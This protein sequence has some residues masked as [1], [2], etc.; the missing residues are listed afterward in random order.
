[1]LRTP[2]AVSKF[3]PLSVPPQE[4]IDLDNG[5]TLH[6]INNGDQPIIRFSLL[7]NSGE[8]DSHPISAAGFVPQI[9]RE[10][11]SRM[12]GAEIAEFV[13]FEGAWL[14]TR[15][16]KHFTG[17][18]VLSLTSSAPKMLD[19]MASM[20]IEPT[21]PEHAFESL[22]TK[23]VKAIEHKMARVD[24]RSQSA[25][26]EHMAGKGHPYIKTLTP[27]QLAATTLDDVKAAFRQGFSNARIH[28]FA[29]G[30]I[31]PEIRQATL[32]FARSLRSPQATYTTS[33]IV[34]MQPG[35]P[36]RHNIVMPDSIQ[37]SVSMAAPTIP[38]SHKDYIPLRIAVMALGGY[39]GSRLMTSIREEKGLT[40]GISAALEGSHEA[41]N[42]TINAQCDP[43]YV[44]EV[45][46]Q[47]FAEIERLANE[48]MPREELEAL[49]QYLSSALAVTLDSP[50][51]IA[52]HYITQLTV[53]TPPDYFEQQFN[54]LGA[55]TPATIAEMTS[56]YIKPELFATFVAGREGNG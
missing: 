23:A 28:L 50:L 44:D 43:A 26:I 17:L 53:G 55:I 15:L 52:D 32:D 41:A 2:P 31:T 6:F 22:R 24:Y 8:A 7:W 49:I 9:L 12:S 16:D 35:A 37:S 5:V 10:G 30:L 45:I 27:A 11:T 18:D 21:F 20:V 54:V 25:M 3:G 13:D 42:I 56:K 34:P 48:P 39:F 1:M 46:S 38:R 36:G 51:S 40:Y 47:T 19:L 29:A 33:R 4:V 14:N